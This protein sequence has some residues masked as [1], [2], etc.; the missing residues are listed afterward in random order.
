MTVPF[1]LA[2]PFFTTRS[3]VYT[4]PDLPFSTTFFAVPVHFLSHTA[5]DLGLSLVPAAISVRVQVQLTFPIL[6]F[7]FLKMSGPA[8]LSGFAP[9]P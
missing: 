7:W 2:F 1:T 4:F 8:R 3:R 9:L 5:L 6:I